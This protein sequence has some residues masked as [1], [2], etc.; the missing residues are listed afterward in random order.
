MAVAGS[1]KNPVPITPIDAS[2]AALGTTSNPIIIQGQT[3]P[4][5]IT[6]R[7]GTLTAANT[8]QTIAVANANRRGFAFQNQS[9][10]SLYLAIGVAATQD[11]LSLLIGPNRL[12][13]TPSNFAPTGSISMIGPTTGQQF[14][15]WEF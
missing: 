13:E 15:F 1:T 12:Y 10:G 8:A 9:A 7:S 2:G 3:A 6:N 14:F 11:K 5:T 4:S